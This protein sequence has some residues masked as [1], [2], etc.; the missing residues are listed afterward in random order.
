MTWIAIAAIFV[1]HLLFAQE[2]HDLAVRALTAVPAMIF[3]LEARTF[4]RDEAG[5]LPFVVLALAQYYMVFGFGVFFDLKFFDLHGPVHFTPNARIS[6][7]VA[8]AVGAVFLAVGARLGRRFGSDLQPTLLR[9]VPPPEV[10]ARWDDAFFIYAGSTIFV[11]FLTVFF[12]NVVPAA[13]ALPA[14]FAFSFDFS[15]GLALVLPPRRLG[16]RAAQLL[17]AIGVINGMARGQLVFRTGMAYVTGRWA[18]VRRVSFRVIAVIMLVYVVVQPVKHTFREQVWA[19]A[20]RT[21]ASIGAVERVDAWGSAFSIYFGDQPLARSEDGGDSAMGRLSELGSVMHA[22]E[23]LPGR[24]EYLEGAGFIPILYAPIPRFIWPDKPTTRDTIQRYGIV[25]GRQG[26]ADAITTAVNLPLLV[27]GYWNFGWP[28]IVLVTLAMGAWMGFAQKLFSGTHWAMR[29]MGVAN[30]TNITVGSPVVLIYS[31]I[32]QTL[33]G[34]LAV[35]WAVYW[36]AK[37]LS[38]R[39]YKAPA[40]IARPRL[41]H[42]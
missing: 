31:A 25:F 7:A 36:L 13:F 17:I 22:F 29:A 41:A 28:G 33:V 32:F 15:M 27:E 9:A 10:P 3:I 42:G 14:L 38:G 4:L 35:A 34:R 23:M 12:P 40:G 26:E 19:P 39:V 2:E 24:V 16:P 30:I 18:A 11:T 5:E 20:T 37:M 8:V 21:G 1:A 6:G